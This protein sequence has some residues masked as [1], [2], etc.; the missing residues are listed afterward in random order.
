[1]ISLQ[2]GSKFWT[3]Y[4]NAVRRVSSLGVLV[5]EEDEG[6][7]GDHGGGGNQESDH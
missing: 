4:L 3:Y 2:A 6:E 1:M 5:H 7:D